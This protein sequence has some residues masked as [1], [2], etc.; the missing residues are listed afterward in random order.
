MDLLL[1]YFESERAESMGEQRG[2]C[3]SE[4]AVKFQKIEN[5][6]GPLAGC[7]STAGKMPALLTLFGDERLWLRLP[8]M[9]GVGHGWRRRVGDEFFQ[10]GLDYFIDA[11]HLNEFQFVP[12]ILRN[13]F[14]IS[15]VA[16]GQ[17]DA[18]D[19]GAMRCQNFVFNAAYRKDETCQRYLFGH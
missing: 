16:S 19:A 7:G 14:K 10:S 4:N 13:V 18:V 15:F 11:M 2:D 17:D 1:C 6:A 3:N 8:R 9:S 5:R 12:H